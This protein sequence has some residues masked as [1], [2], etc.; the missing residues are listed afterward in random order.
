MM[1]Y[2][3]LSV[4]VVYLPTV[5]SLLTVHRLILRAYVRDNTFGYTR[6]NRRAE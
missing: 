5:E 6:G 3:V 2:C 1:G 4:V